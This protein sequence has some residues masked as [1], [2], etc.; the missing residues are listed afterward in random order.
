[1]SARARQLATRELGAGRWRV[2]LA[3]P[4]SDPRVHPDALTVLA[5][6]QAAS[7]ARVESVARGGRPG[8]LS[9]VFA[10]SASAATQ[11]T[12]VHVRGED[13]WAAEIEL[14][15]AAQEPAPPTHRRT[16]SQ[17]ELDLRA[18]D[19]E[20]LRTKLMGMVGGHVG[21]ELQLHPVAEVTALVEL[22]AYLGDA[23]SYSQDAVATEAYLA[24]ARRRVSVT[25]H[26]ALL[27]YRV[28]EGRS[29]RVWVQLSVSSELVLDAGT[30]LLSRVP[31]LPPRVEPAQLPGALAHGALVF[32]TCERVELSPSTQLELDRRWQPD[33]RLQPGATS[34]VVELHG[35]PPAHRSLVAICPARGASSGPAH[36][37]MLSE[38]SQLNGGTLLRWSEQDALPAEV[39]SVAPL[40]VR[41]G[42]LV[43]ADH[44]RSHPWEPL[45]RA[46]GHVSWPLLAHRDP[47]M[48]PV[49]ESP[50]WGPGGSAAILLRADCSTRP[51][52]ELR[53]RVPGGHRRWSQRPSLLGSGPLSREFMVEL[54]SDRSARL[55][56]GDGE[57]GMAPSPQARL[58][59]RMRTG[60]GR[61]GSLAAGALAHVVSG[62]ERLLGV[63]SPAATR[64]GADPEALSSVRLA[65]PRAYR[66]TGRALSA[67]DLIAAALEVPGVG[68]ATA[69]IVET[70]G[71][72]L[73]RVRVAPEDEQRDLD[74]LT[75]RVRAAIALRQPIGVRLD[76]RA[77]RLLAVTVE[78]EITLRFGRGLAAMSGVVDDLLR[79]TLL[80]PG[81]WRFG[82]ALHR[83]DVV[84]LL[85]G[86]PGVLDVTLQRFDWVRSDPSA[87]PPE[88]LLP[89]FG[90]IL[91][92]AQDPDAPEHGS[93]EFRLRV[94]T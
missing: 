45:D 93:F 66:V 31:G 3:V 25:R 13:G 46:E 86:V 30:Q 47:S 27:D 59:V 44:G 23:L 79:R 92:I 67:A 35:R 5:Q 43:V 90:S 91:Q 87:S 73:A 36:V 15:T 88:S 70:G 72:P 64:G 17:T 21:E 94:A 9:V 32:E 50:P 63:S 37:V 71:G 18:R 76:V 7:V 82:E 49:T 40:C 42:N 84:T 77:R 54:E 62:D 78:A 34:A 80:Q 85:A 48:V 68:D 65:A 74:A 89:P 60:S 8:T 1:M 20:A 61:R 28:F 14:G 39:A 33:G 6:A 55:R 19:Y 81:R 2:E 29:A 11:P 52:V 12:R 16:R 69:A 38:V 53:E 83:S 56:F 75:D 41:P 58:E 51:A 24:S 57:Q 4:V 10:L 26:A 22:L